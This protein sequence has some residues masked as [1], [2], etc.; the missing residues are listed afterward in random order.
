MP[1]LGLECFLD[2]EKESQRLRQ[3]IRN[4]ESLL[5]WGPADAGKSALIWKVLSELPRDRARAC[6]AVS[7]V[8]SLQDLLRGLVFALVEA[9]SPYLR[10]KLERENVR[11]AGYLRWLKAQSSL[12]LKGILYRA[13]PE[14]EYWIFLNHLP[15]L[16][17]AAAK[18]VRRFVWMCN[19]PVYLEARGAREGEIGRVAD[20]YWFERHCLALGPLP[21]RAAREL[22][23]LSIRRFGLTKLDVESF[24]EEIL[25]LSGR[26]PGAIVALCA[27]A[28]K[29]EYQFGRQIKT[30]LLHID[31]LMGRDGSAREQQI[32][33]R[34][35]RHE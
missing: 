19:T 27:R 1:V 7:G 24:R 9:G 22:L 5:L 13:L 2:R 26:L 16:S 11:E 15:P 4:R 18:L 3:A 12:R 30:K 32:G 29:P 33:K 8:H 14:R 17:H 35:P 10:E 31:Y 25:R 20:L 34:L 23:E 28:A 21:V 6:L